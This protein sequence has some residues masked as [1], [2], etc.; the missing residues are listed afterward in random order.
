MPGRGG[1]FETCLGGMWNL[2][3]KYQVFPPGIHFFSRDV[4]WRSFFSQKR[5][6]VSSPYLQQPRVFRWNDLTLPV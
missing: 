6:E 3:R 1:D 5:R 2:N 4:G